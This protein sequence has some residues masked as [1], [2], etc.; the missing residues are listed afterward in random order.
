MYC[1]NIEKL[2]EEFRVIVPR[3]VETCLVNRVSEKHSF[4]AEFCSCFSS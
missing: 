4:I 1:I 2:K 3:E